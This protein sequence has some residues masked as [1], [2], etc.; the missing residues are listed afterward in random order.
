[1][2]KNQ[3]DVSEMTKE[4]MKAEGLQELEQEAHQRKQSGSGWGCKEGGG[5]IYE[6]SQAAPGRN[7]DASAELVDSRS[8]D[9]QPPRLP[10]VEAQNGIIHRQFEYQ[11]E[12]EANR[13]A[14]LG[15]GCQ[16]GF[17]HQNSQYFYQRYPQ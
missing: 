9:Q 17:A 1:M 4:H 12:P 5:R 15:Y 7:L 2:R 8:M 16:A 14:P 11:Q 3:S 13:Q 10:F 6:S